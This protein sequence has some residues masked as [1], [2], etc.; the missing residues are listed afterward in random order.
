MFYAFTQGPDHNAI[1]VYLC[2]SE[3]D[4]KLFILDDQFNEIACDDDACVCKPTFGFQ[5]F[6]ICVPVAPGD[7]VHIAVDGL[8]GRRRPLRDSRRSV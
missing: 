5:S 1:S 3:Y 7:T 6:L 4:T 8:V 2:E